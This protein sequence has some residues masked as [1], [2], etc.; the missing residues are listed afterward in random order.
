MH[1]MRKDKWHDRSINLKHQAGG[2]L[3]GTNSHTY[4]TEVGVCTASKGGEGM[5]DIAGAKTKRRRR[6]T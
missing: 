1:K 4:H 3:K 2:K 5:M 6:R